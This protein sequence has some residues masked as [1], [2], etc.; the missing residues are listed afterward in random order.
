VKTYEA[1]V[2][3]DNVPPAGVPESF[4]VLIKELQSLALDIKVLSDTREEIM[5]GEDDDDEAVPMDVNLSGLE[6]APISLAALGDEEDEELDDFDD[7]DDFEDAEEE[8][9][10]TDE[11]PEP[12][13]E[14]LAGLDEDLGELSDA[15]DIDIDKDLN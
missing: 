5:I 10:L 7:F 3:G 14:E 8:P 9:V 2:K 13:G 4:K 15:L 12:N 1:I 11:E 6:D